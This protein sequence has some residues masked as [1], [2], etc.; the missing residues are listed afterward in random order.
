MSVVHNTAD[1][2]GP[3]TGIETRAKLRRIRPG[4][5][6]CEHGTDRPVDE[7]GYLRTASKRPGIDSSVQGECDSRDGKGDTHGYASDVLSAVA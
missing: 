7:S 4:L 2:A 1:I 3:Q 6:Y 5:R